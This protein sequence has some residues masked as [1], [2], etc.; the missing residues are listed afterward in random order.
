MSPLC[1]SAWHAPPTCASARVFLPA[2]TPRP[3]C[4]PLSTPQ[5]SMKAGEDGEQTLVAS[6]SYSVFVLHHSCTLVY[7]I[8]LPEA[9]PVTAL[10]KIRLHFA[11]IREFCPRGNATVTTA[12]ASGLLTSCF[13][14]FY[15]CG[16]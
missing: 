15:P 1:V 14:M 8:P 3:T 12:V 9:V 2:L 16:R 4:V 5:N 7:T 6:I 13:S 11:A 10:P